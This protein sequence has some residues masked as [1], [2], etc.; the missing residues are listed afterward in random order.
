MKIFKETAKHIT[1]VF[2]ANMIER[3]AREWPPTCLM[4]A[5]QPERPHCHLNCTQ[6]EST[7]STLP[8]R[9]E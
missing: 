4:F 8:E 9:K 2:V 3:D 7:H 6:D 5:Y 1:K